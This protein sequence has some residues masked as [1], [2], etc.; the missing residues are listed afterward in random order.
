MY[1]TGPLIVMVHVANSMQETYAVGGE[2]AHYGSEPFI[3]CI[4]IHIGCL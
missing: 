2:L 4:G 1:R 3:I